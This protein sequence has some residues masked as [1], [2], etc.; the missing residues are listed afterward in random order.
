MDLLLKRNKAYEAVFQYLVE[1]KF[2]KVKDEVRF[3][4]IKEEGILQ[5]KRYL[6]SDDIRSMDNLRSFLI[7]FHNK[8]EGEIIEVR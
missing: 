5:L 6:E 3:E 7:I 2:I 4:K 1:F 8:I